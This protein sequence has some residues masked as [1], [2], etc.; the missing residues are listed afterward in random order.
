MAEI[1]QRTTSHNP[2]TL[3]ALAH[4]LRIQLI[5]ALREYGPATA[6]QLAARLGESSGATSYHLRQLAAHGFIEEA[7]ERSTGRERWWKATHRGTRTD[8]I[9][10]F[11]HHP[12]PAV[13]GALGLFIHETAHTHAQELSAWLHTMHEWPE[14]WNRSWDLSNFTLRITP[15]QARELEGKIH[16]LIESYREM[17]EGDPS[18]DVA[19]RIHVHAFP[20]TSE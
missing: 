15:D 20:H 18:E 16:D 6:S 19:L 13:R 3:Q 9:E 10:D 1:E 5:T 8:N 11:M 14:A 4:P 12:D 7:S 17:E 2:R